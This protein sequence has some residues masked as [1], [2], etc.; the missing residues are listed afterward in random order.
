MKKSKKLLTLATTLLVT[1]LS[2]SAPLASH[3][4]E[5][6][7]SDKIAV[8]T[9]G[10]KL[11]PASITVD[12]TVSEVIEVRGM[13][14]SIDQENQRF[15]LINS[16][17]SYGILPIWV[18]TDDVELF[19]QIVEGMDVTVSLSGRIL[20]S[21]PAQGKANKVIINET[22][23]VI[24]DTFDMDHRGWTGDFA[25]YPVDYDESQYQLEYARESVPSEI[26][27][28]SNALFLSGVNRSDDL[29]M[30]IKKKVDMS[31]GLKP[32]TNYLVNFE[33]EIAS[34]APAGAFGV[35]GAPGESVYVKAGATTEEPSLII[36]D[37]YYRMN[38]DKGNQSTS[39]K[40]AIVLGNLAKVSGTFDFSYELINFNNLNFKDA[41]IA[42]TDENG[43]LWLLIGTDSGFEGITSIYIPKVKATFTEAQVSN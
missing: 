37:G 20:K 32:N 26:E 7:L 16:N 18:H 39:G 41:F 10:N 15:L 42:K 34:N 8:D 19:N 38:I 17:T 22:K 6:Q 12:N 24:E 28:E 3:G 1:T 43:E 5:T 23:V 33:F 21:F 9:A 14:D 11:K 2:L 13:V 31:Y 36:Q 27:P 35:G 30:F 40:D 4:A 29:F 25:D